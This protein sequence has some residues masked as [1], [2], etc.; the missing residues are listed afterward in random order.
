MLMELLESF[1]MWWSEVCASLGPRSLVLTMS[2]A[3]NLSLASVMEQKQIRYQATLLE[4]VKMIVLV[5]VGIRPN[6]KFISG[7]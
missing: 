3:C 7:L 6:Q 2:L 5:D 1:V 4:L